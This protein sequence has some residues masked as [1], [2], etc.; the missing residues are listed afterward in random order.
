[1]RLGGYGG[2]HSGFGGCG[3]FPCRGGWRGGYGGWHGGYAGW[4]GY[5]HGYWGPALSV[6]LLGG[7]YGASSYYG[8]SGYYGNNAYYDDGCTQHRRVY[9]RWGRYLGWQPVNVC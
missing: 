8:D 6:G 3:L 2:Y 7:Y 4:R 5:R 9:D 1:M